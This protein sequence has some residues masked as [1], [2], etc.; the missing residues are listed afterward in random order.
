MCLLHNN[1]CFQ[2]N[3]AITNF[4]V[5]LTYGIRFN[6]VI[7]RST[8]PMYSKAKIPKYDCHGHVLKPSLTVAIKFYQTRPE[9]RYQARHRLA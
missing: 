2:S 8:R 5:S 6:D 7:G 9:K 1:P 3:I 4:L